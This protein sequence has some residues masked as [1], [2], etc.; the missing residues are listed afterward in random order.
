MDILWERIC[1]RG[2]PEESGIDPRFLSR[3]QRCHDDWLLHR[4]STFPTP[5]G[6]DRVLVLDGNLSKAQFLQMVRER[7]DEILGRK[8][9]IDE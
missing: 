7:E 2:R 3:L 1:R 8:E 9:I 5:A 6:D 4:N